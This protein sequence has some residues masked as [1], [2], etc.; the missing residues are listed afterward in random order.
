M[1]GRVFVF[2]EHYIFTHPGTLDVLMLGTLHL[3]FVNTKP[4]SETLYI[5]K[6]EIKA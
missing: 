1:C 2:S 4:L 6:K 5:D 3:R